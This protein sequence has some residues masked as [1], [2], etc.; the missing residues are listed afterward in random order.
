MKENIFKYINIERI[1][2]ALLLLFLLANFKYCGDKP[3][4]QETVK[5]E[6]IITE[7]LDSLLNDKLSRFK[8][9]KQLVYLEGDKVTEVPKNYVMPVSA[10]GTVK[11]LMKVKDTAVLSNGTINAEIITDGKIYS[12][13]YKLFTKDTTVV[14]TIERVERYDRSGLFITAGNVLGTD[15][16]VKDINAGLQYVHRNRWLVELNGN[17]TLDSFTP[18]DKRLGVGLKVGFKIN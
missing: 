11:E 5:T 17:Y 16:R 9:E 12:T 15:L 2:I 6:L 10:A 13:K 1:I 14:R 3:V 8:P 7:K 4:V 18:S